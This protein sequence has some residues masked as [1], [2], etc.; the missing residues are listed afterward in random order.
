MAFKHIVNQITLF[1]NLNK[2][3]Q[4]PYTCAVLK[5]C[6]SPSQLTFFGDQRLG[7]QIHT[8]GFLSSPP[9]H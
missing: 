2:I 6:F 7:F 5:K 1:W 4:I 8:G 3:Y 9:L